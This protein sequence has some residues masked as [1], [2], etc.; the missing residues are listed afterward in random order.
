MRQAARN[1]LRYGVLLV[2]AL[3]FLAPLLMMLAGSF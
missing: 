3:L 1:G 2:S